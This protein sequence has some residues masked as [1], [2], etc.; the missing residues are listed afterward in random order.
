MRAH[1][2]LLG[3]WIVLLLPTIT[4]SQQAEQPWFR[5]AS[6]DYGPIGGGPPA[7]TDL[8][9]DGFPDLICDGK[10]FKN[11]GGKRFL[12]VTKEAGVAGH[13]QRRPSG[14]L[15]LRRRGLALP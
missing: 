13:R 3:L 4:V 15:F 11:D 8:D 5:D 9:G 2:I 10:V 14:H 6:K 1:S 12:D 7:L